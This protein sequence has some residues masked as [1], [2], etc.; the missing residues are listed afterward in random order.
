MTWQLAFS[1]KFHT[2][3]QE[4]VNFFPNC[5]LFSKFFVFSLYDVGESFPPE[6]F[7]L[8]H[9]GYVYF[10]LYLYFLFFTK[11]MT[12]WLN[13]YKKANTRQKPD[14][15]FSFLVA[16]QIYFWTPFHL[17]SRCQCS[18]NNFNITHFYIFVLHG[19]L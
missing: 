11:W 17:T 7:L 9:E 4:Y 6:H 14:L 3:Q 15:W 5:F 19:R 13:L 12:K 10:F 2:L 1:W 8:H 18:Y 16:R